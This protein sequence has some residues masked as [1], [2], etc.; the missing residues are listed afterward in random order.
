MEKTFEVKKE[1][2]KSIK[3]QLAE[4][5]KFCRQNQYNRAY[6]KIMSIPIKNCSSHIKIIVKFFGENFLLEKEVREKLKNIIV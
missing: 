3:L 1:E 2:A 5:D 4:I 6:L